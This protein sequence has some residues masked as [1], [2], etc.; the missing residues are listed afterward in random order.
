MSPMRTRPAMDPERPPMIACFWEPLLVVWSAV[1]EGAEAPSC[2]FVGLT[3]E[4]VPDGCTLVAKV[5]KGT[6][7][8]PVLDPDICN[9][10]GVADEGLVQEVDSLRVVLVDAIGAYDGVKSVVSCTVTN[11][12]RK[13]V[14][15]T[16]TVEIGIATLVVIICPVGGAAVVG[17]DGAAVDTSSKLVDAAVSGGRKMSPNSEVTWS[18][19]E[20]RGIS[21]RS[22]SL[23]NTSSF[24]LPFVIVANSDRSRFCFASF[25][26]HGA[27]RA[28]CHLGA[29]KQK[30]SRFKQWV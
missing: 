22:I 17:V 8:V 10:G 26:P 21:R 5:G 24:C 1:A 11:V 16:V 27:S 23:P 2:V 14:S 30:P 4:E 19:I 6:G 29:P 9:G 13:L 7:S 25:R 28:L 12:V 18:Q 20:D 3:V 15:A